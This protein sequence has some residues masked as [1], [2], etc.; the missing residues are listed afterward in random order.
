MRVMPKLTARGKRVGR[1]AAGAVLIAGAGVLVHRL[2][3]GA[4]PR[5]QWVIPAVWAAAIV[6]YLVAGWIGSRRTLDH[7]DELAVPGLVVPSVGAAL[8]LPLTLHLAVAAAI[9]YPLREFDGWV[10][11]SVVFTGPTH[12]VLALLVGQRARQLAT[13]VPALS[14]AKIY[15]ICVG[16]SCLPFAILVLPPLVVGLTGLPMAALMAWMGPLAARDRLHAMREAVPRATA[17]Q[18]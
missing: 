6:A 10:L 9:A 16:V 17:V 18:R 5:S 13:G 12:L 14:P 7:A 8:L 4:E 3:D 1:I 11:I 2:V 15:G